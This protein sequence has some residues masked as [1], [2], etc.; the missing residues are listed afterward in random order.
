MA[1]LPRL[2]D[3]CIID[4]P[5]IEGIVIHV[6]RATII[7]NEVRGSTERGIAVTEMSAG[8]IEGNRVFDSIGSAFYCGDMSRCSVVDNV[9]DQVASAGIGFRSTDG[10][11]LVIHFHSIAFVDELRVTDVTGDD[12]VVMLDSNLSPVS[13]YP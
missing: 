6:S 5:V 8:R 7:G 2:I 9:A 3:G 11:G 10:H 1:D 4:G 12:I 13:V